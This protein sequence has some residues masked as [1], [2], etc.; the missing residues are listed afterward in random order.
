MFQKGIIQGL[1]L[2]LSS[3]L[4]DASPVMAVGHSAPEMIKRHWLSRYWWRTGEIWRTPVKT[5]HFPHL[6]TMI[7]DTLFVF[8]PTYAPSQKQAKI[9]GD[10]YYVTAHGFIVLLSICVIKNDGLKWITK[11][12]FIEAL[13][14]T[15]LYTFSMGQEK[16]SVNLVMRLQ[17]SYVHASTTGFTRP[18][19]HPSSP[20]V[21]LLP[22]GISFLNLMLSS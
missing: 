5:N 17:V 3:Y 14:D 8:R 16:K 18:R 1:G 7:S 11:K 20:F 4:R 15:L 12:G 10:W 2:P 6:V 21:S 13:T 19:P 9:T 22:S